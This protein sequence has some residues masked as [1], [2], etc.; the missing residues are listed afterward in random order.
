MMEYQAEATRRYHALSKLPSETAASQD[1]RFTSKDPETRPERFKTYSGL[2]QVELPADLT[3][4]SKDAFDALRDKVGSSSG[5]VVQRDL[6]R[7][8]F[9]AAGVVRTDSDGQ[10]VKAFFRAAMSA[11]N[12]HPLELYVASGG[13]EGVAAG[14]YHFDP[15]PFALTQL[16][17]EDAGTCLAEASGVDAPARAAV[18]VVVTAIPWRQAWK[19]GE[20]GWRHL[21]WDAGTMLANLLAAAASADLQASVLTSFVDEEVSTALGLDATVEFPLLVVSIGKRLD[22]PKGSPARPESDSTAVPTSPITFPLTRAVQSEGVLESVDDVRRWRAAGS[23]PPWAT[24]VDVGY[25]TGSSLDEVIMRRGS[26]RRMRHEQLSAAATQAILQ[27]PDLGLELDV[28]LTLLGSMTHHVIVHSAEGR[29]AGAYVLQEGDLV[30]QKAGSFRRVAQRLCHDQALGG[31]AALTFF[32]MIDL[33]RVLAELGPR[34]Y[35]LANLEAGII[36]GRLALA[37]F[38]HGAGATSLTFFDDEV[39]AFL[40]T[41]NACVLVTAVGLPDYRSL[42]GGQPRA[43]VELVHYQSLVQSLRGATE[44]RSDG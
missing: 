40:E 33:D 26:T 39:S 43:P 8:L 41:Q 15:L 7:L 44:A 38:A 22:Q 29:E 21:Y 4:S 18:S 12:L 34:G 13:V 11:G 10:G 35:R 14:L 31:D 42:P 27:V 3:P 37:S 30:L 19:Y 20:R 6:A 24:A 2:P 23:T 28:S 1:P 16:S 9:L 17:S 5:L 25:P 36:S 32:H